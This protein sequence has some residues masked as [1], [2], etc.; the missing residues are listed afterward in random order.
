MRRAFLAILFALS[1]A[2]CTKTAF[3]DPLKGNQP[4]NATQIDALI[5]SAI[6]TKGFFSWDMAND[7]MISTALNE[8]DNILSVGYKTNQSPVDISNSI[9][10]IDVESAPWIQARE[11]VIEMILEK[12]KELDK[13]L[14]KEQ[15][16]QWQ[17]LYLPVIDVYVR[18][19]ETI[20]L[21]RSSNLIRYAEPM[22]YEPRDVAV[23]VASGSGCGGNT[24]DNS[25]VSGVDFTSILPNSKQSWNYGFH[26]IGAAWGKSTGAGIKVFIIDTGAEFD[27][28]NLGS[29]FNQGN[30][31][32][33]T[34]E[35][36]VT[37]PRATFLGI[38]TGSV[39]TPDDGCGHGTAMAG[40]LAAPR[41]TD[42]AACGVAYNCNLVTCRASTDVYLDESREIKGASDA[43]VNAGNRADV[44]IISMS[45]GK[46]TSS[47][48]L[49]DAIRYANNKG[50]LIFCAAGTSFS[51]T[52]GWF[53]VIFPA[54]M[55]EVNAVTGV[56]D[57][58][59]TTTCDICHSG[60]ETDFTVVMQRSGTN[61]TALS[62]SMAGDT[63]STVGGS[64]VATATAAGVA[65]LVW[66]RFPAFNKTQILNK[67]VTTSANYPNRS[68]VLGW[69]NLNAD[70]AT[71]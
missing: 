16:I 68:S 5:R 71:N 11:L 8:S 44:R 35:R 14:T 24:A 30:S 45:M 70:A 58:S 50:K 56:T 64:S 37:L 33:R 23:K 1:F 46:I 7:E 63:P 61:R 40:A 54:Y 62:L 29:A 28:D 27:Q 9:H 18:N 25:L 49:A 41:G 69:G 2:S 57:K 59:F 65:A 19:P 38:P 34:I 20:K 22:G 43:F 21:L 51:W 4:A 12:E 13:S 53:G 55:P 17:D 3:E 47:S 15:L 48:Q 36:I 6:Q 67:L 52:N 66:S 42:G 39:E 10:L 31:T 60:A 26:N 32:G